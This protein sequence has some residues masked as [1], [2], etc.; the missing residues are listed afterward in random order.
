MEDSE[1]KERRGRSGKVGKVR[2]RA[3]LTRSP[4]GILGI[5]VLSRLALEGAE[6]HQTTT[7][8]RH[9]EEPSRREAGLR[10]REP[11]TPE[12]PPVRSASLSAPAANGE[13][14]RPRR[15][16]GPREEKCPKGFLAEARKWLLSEMLDLE[17]HE[18][19]LLELFARR[20][21]G[22]KHSL[23]RSREVGVSTAHCA[24]A[25]REA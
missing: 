16:A 11:E 19:E 3:A 15:E 1:E 12:A 18:G 10:L 17:T 2:I 23:E 6:A 22:V 24:L 20:K 8:K 7:P 4:R 9:R 14:N 13:S 25:R 21:I 5:R